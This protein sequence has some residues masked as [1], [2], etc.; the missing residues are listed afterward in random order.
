[1]SNY[2][3]QNIEKWAYRHFGLVLLESQQEKIALVL[4]R[5]LEK[6]QLSEH[7]FLELLREEDKKTQEDLVDLITIQESYF[8][9]DA[10][11][12]S[13]L[14]NLFLP[15]LIEQKKRSKSLTIWSAG[16]ASGEELYSIAILLFELIPDLKDW[17]INLLGTDICKDALAKAES[18]SYSQMALRATGQETKGKYFEHQGSMYQLIE[19]IRRM[20]HFSYGNLLKP[21]KFSAYV[22]LIFCRNVFIYFDEKSIDKA[23]EN[24]KQALTKD[25]ILFLGSSDFVRY[26]QRQ[27][28]I[29]F[30]D[31]VTYLT[32]QKIED[33]RLVRTEKPSFASS[34]LDKQA[35]V[36]QW[37]K[38]VDEML[39]KKQFMNI[40][41]L[42]DKELTLFNPKPILY[43]YKGEALIGL[44][45]IDTA[46]E[47]LEKAIQ[48]DAR[49][50][51]TCVL[52]ALVWMQED[53][54]KAQEYLSC[55]IKM[56]QM[57]P[58]A[59]YYL[60]MLYL[61]EQEKEL[62]L[63]HLTLAKQY[64]EA[65]DGDK[66]VLGSESTM[67]EFAEAV[68]DEVGYYQERSK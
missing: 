54:K 19:P 14:K 5:Y 21:P 7:D 23:L 51:M 30:K 37:H 4:G 53:K 27:F 26:H 32:K 46:K 47:V 18:G 65:E 36:L 31:G 49:D 29:N 61:G 48:V 2:L 33:E 8:F 43:R 45:D 24:F 1:M 11:L 42:V 68:S 34:Y 3:I 40:V 67:R 13:A 55:A 63:E 60:A 35:K 6:Q 41:T 15:H 44:G 39:R 9:R 17:Q 10:S 38:S 64:A 16:C 56:K 28:V 52:L 25:G 58:E 57:F 62:G 50:P 20:A 59:H 22:D 12:F 66:R